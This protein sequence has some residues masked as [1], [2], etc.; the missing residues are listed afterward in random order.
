MSVKS[1]RRCTIVEDLAKDAIVSH[2]Y[3]SYIPKT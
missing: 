1:C 2:T 3:D